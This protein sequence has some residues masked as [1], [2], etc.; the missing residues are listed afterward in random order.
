MKKIVILLLLCSICACA[1]LVYMLAL[2]MA[3]SNASDSIRNM[4]MVKWSSSST[5]KTSFACDHEKVIC[6]WSCSTK[7]HSQNNLYMH[8]ICFKK[9]LF[10]WSALSPREAQGLSL[11]L[12]LVS[13]IYPYGQSN[14]LMRFKNE[15]AFSVVNM[16]IFIVITIRH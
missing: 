2:F 11:K 9:S 4:L 13:R 7:N 16:H 3:R 6:C 8:K 1:N 10:F 12:K 15:M 14:V 5:S